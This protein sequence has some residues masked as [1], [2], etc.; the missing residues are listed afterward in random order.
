MPSVT[1]IVILIA[2][3]YELAVDFLNATS[4]SGLELL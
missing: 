2:K 3:N 4:I 1:A